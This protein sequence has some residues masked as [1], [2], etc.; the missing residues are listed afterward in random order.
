VT[1]KRG[2][3]RPTGAAGPRTQT[4]SLRISDSE[5]AAWDRAAAALGAELGRPVPVTEWI[6]LACERVLADNQPKET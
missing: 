2:R 3:G 4:V 5:R 6:R 1:P